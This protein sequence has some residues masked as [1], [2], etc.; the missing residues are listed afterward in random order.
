VVLDRREECLPCEYVVAYNVELL[1]E[2]HLRVRLPALW[3]ILVRSMR[4]GYLQNDS[5]R[6][7]VH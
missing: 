1:V 2:L 6:G 5:G 3:R 7:S 4:H